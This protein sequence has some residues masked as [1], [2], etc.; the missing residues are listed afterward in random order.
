MSETQ[1]FAELDK[2]V[3]G[4]KEISGLPEKERNKTPQHKKWRAALD[5]LPKK[6]QEEYKQQ[7][8]DEAVKD[9][10]EGRQALKELCER[11]KVHPYAGE[12][13]KNKLEEDSIFTAQAARDAYPEIG[14]Q[15]L[16]NTE[17]VFFA[18]AESGK[19]RNSGGFEWAHQQVKMNKEKGGTAFAN[20]TN[21]R[22]STHRLFRIFTHTG[23]LNII[24]M[25]NLIKTGYY[26]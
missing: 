6:D 13:L 11:T 10:K 1:K 12:W 25:L 8:F 20:F 4:L 3:G 14:P 21:T 19:K 18:F 9:K 7:K 24:C 23:V 15:D 26:L 5:A 17:T 22:N 16:S 2:L